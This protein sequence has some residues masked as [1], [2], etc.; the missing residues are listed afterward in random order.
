MPRSRRP[1]AIWILV[2]IGGMVAGGFLASLRWQ[3]RAHYTGREEVKLKSKLNQA[4]SEQRYLVV[5]Q[6]G[7]RTPREIERAAN[8]RG[9]L[10]PATLDEPS[11]LRIPYQLAAQQVRT[12]ERERRESVKE[13]G[14]E[15]NSERGG[16][17]NEK[18]NEKAS[19]KSNERGNARGNEASKGNPVVE[20][21][22]GPTTI[23]PK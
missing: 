23:P 9:A 15:A 12:R 16:R 1:N 6:S 22:I 13:R 21:A 7:A 3:Q 18:A 20:A 2:I 14:N 17:G 10:A 5:D 8:K 4:E 19:E 11:A